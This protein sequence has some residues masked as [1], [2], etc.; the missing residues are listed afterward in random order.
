MIIPQIAENLTKSGNLVIPDK[1][2]VCHKI[3]Q[4]TS[5]G[6]VFFVFIQLGVH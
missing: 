6:G 3:Y 5:Y 1:C 4:N 2:P